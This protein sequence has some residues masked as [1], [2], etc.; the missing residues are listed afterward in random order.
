MYSTQKNADYDRHSV[1]IYEEL[2]RMPPFQRKT[3]VLVGADSA[4]KDSL[5]SKL[6]TK[7]PDRLGKSRD[8]SR[9]TTR[10]R[11]RDTGC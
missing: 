8:T 1:P 3:M 4:G 9:G 7:D 5:V 6:L 11:T 10:G 2:A